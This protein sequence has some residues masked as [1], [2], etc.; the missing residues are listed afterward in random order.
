[1][2][3][4]IEWLKGCTTAGYG[5]TFRDGKVQ[6][7]HR[8]AWAD[9]NG[10]I[11]EGMT[12][13]HLCENRRCINVEHMEL[14]RRDDHAGALGHGKLTREQA[15]EIRELL[16][17]GWLQRE[18]ADA[19]GVSPALVSLIKSGHRWPEQMAVAA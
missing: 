1:M 13:H 16:G 14:L 5:E 9:A 12:V 19:Y 10:P 6:Y 4:C 7:A 11:P 3:G 18:A 8:L 15:R 17:A 2:T